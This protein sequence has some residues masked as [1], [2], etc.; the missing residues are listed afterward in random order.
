MSFGGRSLAGAAA[1]SLAVALSGCGG[2]TSGQPT[3]A[4]STSGVAAPPSQGADPSPAVYTPSAREKAT[5]VSFVAC[6]RLPAKAGT[7]HLAPVADI[8]AGNADD[9]PAPRIPLGVVRLEGAG[10]LA[11]RQG[12]IGAG[13][14]FDAAAGVESV[15]VRVADEP[16][17]APVTLA[18]LDSV[19]AG[20]RVAFVE[21]QVRTTTPVRWVEVRPLLIAT[22]GGDGGFVRG[23]APDASD[24]VA[25]DDGSPQDYVGA[26]FPNGNSASENVCVQRLSSSGEIDAVLFSTGY[27]D[28]GYPTFAGYDA[29]GRVASLVS[30]GYVLPWRYSGLPGAPPS[31]PEVG[32]IP[33]ASL[34][35]SSTPTPATP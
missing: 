22:D 13:S 31:D 5:G 11:L 24:V 28:G 21:V 18:V 27:G 6:P 23:E 2:G 32:G 7:T 1:V 34:S 12:T 10:S 19:Q 8:D 20:R 33:Y 15:V 35:P 9:P 3:R 14:G 26:F 17:T 4:A 16:V 29:S 30:F 25:I